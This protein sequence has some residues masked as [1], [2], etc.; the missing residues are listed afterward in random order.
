MIRFTSTEKWQD[1]WYRQLPPYHKLIWEYLRD[2]CNNAG[3]IELDSEQISFSTG[4]P[5]EEI[6]K[7]IK[8]LDRGY[9]GAKEGHKDWIWIKNF[10]KHQKNLPLNPNNNSHKQII[11]LIGDQHK[12]FDIQSIIDYIQEDKSV[13]RIN[14]SAKKKKALP[15]D[16]D[17]IKHVELKEAQF[18][19]FW[20]MYDYKK[21]PSKAKELFMKLKDDEIVAIFKQLPAYV[22][23]TTPNTDKNS[24][25]QF[26]ML[27]TTYLNGQRWEDE[28]KT[29]IRSEGG[30]DTHVMQG[31]IGEKK[32]GGMHA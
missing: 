28:I 10:L 12:R 25:L 18:E 1:K 22:K 23:S 7:I 2:C 3:F 5:R 19:K 13:F 26:R 27:P 15:P 4:I 20:T 11:F 21:N 6:P 16:E 17:E 29:Y 30:G 32:G 14:K 24:T 31:S 9:L 8:G